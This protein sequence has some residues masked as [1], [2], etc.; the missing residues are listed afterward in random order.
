MKDAE[1][2]LDAILKIRAEVV[3]ILIG[4]GLFLLG[5]SNPPDCAT[6]FL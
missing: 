6:S 4:T 5:T 3:L 1:K 2:T